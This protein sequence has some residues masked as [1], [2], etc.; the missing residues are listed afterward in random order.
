MNKRLSDELLI[1]STMMTVA[2]DRSEIL[3]VANDLNNLIV[4]TMELE[5]TNSISSSIETKKTLSASIKFTKQEIDKMSKTFKKQ[6]IAN[7]CIAHIIKRPSGKNGIYYEIR[8]RRNGYNITVSNADLKTA[9]ILFIEAT[10]ALESPELLSKDKLKFHSVLSEWLKFKQGK[11]ATKTWQNYD[12]ISK[13]L[14]P[15][16][17]LERPIVEI[18]TVDL[19]NVMRQ[20]NDNPRRYEDMRTV[21]NQTFKYAVASGIIVHNPITLVPF[22][23]AERKKRNRLSDV[24]LYSFLSRLK[25]P[26]YTQIRQL[27]Y[28]LYFFGLRPCE[29][30]NEAHF[31]NGFLICRNR[32]RKNGKIEYKKI[33]VPEQAQGLIEFDKTIKPAISYNKWLKLIKEALGDGLTPYNLRHT[34]ASLCAESLREEIVDVW[35]GDSSERLVGKTYIH[36]SDEFMKKE[37]NKVNFII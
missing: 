30:D 10:K 6:F 3:K 18:R 34:F 21:F 9:K 27:A 15:E 7:G 19:D 16:S 5:K 31:E 12:S 37:M 4:K 1:I 11:I 14:I 20:F 33:P 32:K 26:E 8:Y 25:R 23:R 13:R 35:M 22:K 28:V 24:Q 29:V 17:L 2:K 36:Y